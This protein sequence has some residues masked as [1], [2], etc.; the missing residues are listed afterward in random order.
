MTLR[1]VEFQRRIPYLQSLDYYQSSDAGD[2][3]PAV[4][5]A[6][7][8][9]SGVRGEIVLPNRAEVHKTTITPGS[10]VTIRGGGSATELVHSG[11]L[12]LIWT[13][14]NNTATGAKTA[15][16][17]DALAGGGTVTLPTGAGAGFTRGDYIALES[18]AIVYAPSGKAYDI[19]QVRGVAGDVLTIE[20]ALI[21]SFLVSDTATYAKWTPLVGITV[22]DLLCTNPDPATYVGES[23]RIDNATDVRVSDIT[24][25]DGGGGVGFRNVLHGTIERQN[26]NE[27]RNG[28]SVNPVNTGQGYGIYLAG[29]CSKIV[30]SGL[31]SRAVR[32][33]FTTVSDQRDA[34]TF[35]GGPHDCVIA[36]SVSV[37][38]PNTD[39]LGTSHFDSH[40]FGHYITYDSCIADGGGEA[41][42]QVRA[43]EVSLVNCRAFR[44][45][46]RGISG[47][48]N[49]ENLSVQGGEFAYNKGTAGFALSG[50]GSRLFGAWV[51]HNEQYGGAVT[52]SDA[53]RPNSVENCRIENNGTIG[54]YSGIQDQSSVAGTVI[55]GCVIPQSA[56]Q[57]I[58]ISN[59]AA[60]SLA[61]NNICLGYA[62]ESVAFF[63]GVDAAIFRNNIT[64]T[65]SRAVLNADYTMGSYDRT[66]LVTAGATNRTATLPLAAS[67]K[68]ERVYIEKVDS[69]AGTVTVDGNGA[70][71]IA[72]AA[73]KTL[74]AQFSAITIISDGTNWRL[75]SSIGTVS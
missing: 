39:G 4:N 31:R 35:Y 12:R 41:G 50:P 17:V 38:E 10:N 15:L 26:N 43:K 55:S 49:G 68:G 34:V 30:V 37:Q 16:T 67:C 60:G 29:P 44:C 40:E 53:A 74:G 11:V 28:W 19:R 9:L 59:A 65:N 58:A 70:E 8:A 7:A 22:K 75:V 56:T 42:F 36:N 25:R 2:Y 72:G 57:N 54:T 21:H 18:N 5:R 73:T 1:E 51:H 71:T 20:G 46:A 23:I 45:G 62:S 32:H 63:G 3:S 64:S 61:T 47:T 13:G 27:L 6:I 52:S 48:V 14:V 24:I 66:M 69:G 33:A